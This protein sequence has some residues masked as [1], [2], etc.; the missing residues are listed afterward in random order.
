[1][2][3]EIEMGHLATIRHQRAIKN[4]VFGLERLFQNGQIQLEPL[5][6]TDIDPG[7]SESKCPDVILQDNQ[8]STVPVIIE[9]ATNR[10]AKTDFSKMR[11]LIDDT[12]YGI[13]EG[14]VLNFETGAWL[15]YSKELGI[16]EENPAWSDVLG[17]NLSEF[18]S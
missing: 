16:V 6:E 11:R 18:I 1:M 3:A 10:G 17:L 15:K 4:I 14:F 5:P 2:I 12:E 13:V 9:I 7:N 8:K